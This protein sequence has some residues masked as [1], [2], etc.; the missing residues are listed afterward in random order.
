M[1]VVV[2]VVVVI[3]AVVVEVVVLELLVVAAAETG[4]SDYDFS[5]KKNKNKKE[6]QAQLGLPHSEIQDELDQSDKIFDNTRRYKLSL[7]S[8]CQLELAKFLILSRIQDRAKVF[9]AQK[10]DTSQKK[11]LLGGGDTAH[12]F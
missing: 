6:K 5:I 2:V 10:G 7:A 9:K 1:E 11:F 3:V 8:S 12:I 4:R